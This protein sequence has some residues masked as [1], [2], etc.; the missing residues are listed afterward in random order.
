MSTGSVERE[1]AELQYRRERINH[2]NAL[3]FDAHERYSRARRTNN[4]I[5][6]ALALEEMG[7][8][9][10]IQVAHTARVRELITQKG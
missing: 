10:S 2:L 8:T 7:M 6:R 4:L 5:E 3:W 1:Q 9:L